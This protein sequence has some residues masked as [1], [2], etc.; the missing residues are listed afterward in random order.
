[1]EL[2]KESE[3]L[4]C[5]IYADF[6]KKRKA[7]LSKTKSKLLGSSY[8]IHQH[9]CSDWDFEDVDDSCRELNR[10]ELLDCFW[11]DGIA[12]NVSLTDI[13]IS[14]MENR[15]KNNLNEITDFITKFIP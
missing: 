4:L 14:H 11:A 1:M 3:K 6:L 2:T 12:Y 9:L 5:L 15:F 8:D 7:D 13:G 10:A